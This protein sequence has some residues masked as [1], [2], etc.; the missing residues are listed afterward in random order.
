[1]L[2]D[3]EEPRQQESQETKVEAPVVEEAM[4]PEEKQEVPVA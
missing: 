2:V 3:S 4:N 1:M